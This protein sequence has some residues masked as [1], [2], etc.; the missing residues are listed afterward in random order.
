MRCDV[1]LPTVR[2]RIGRTPR[3]L[4]HGPGNSVARQ[5]GA[6]ARRTYARRVRLRRAPGPAR[7][8]AVLAAGVVTLGLLAATVAGCQADPAGGPTSSAAPSGAASGRPTP[9][10]GS[11]G[12]ASSPASTPDADGSVMSPP[13]PQQSPF[14]AAPLQPG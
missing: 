5:P 2:G 9:S 12:P 13:L 11:S 10:S 6:R 1:G 3:E 4:D 7:T 14:V 8:P